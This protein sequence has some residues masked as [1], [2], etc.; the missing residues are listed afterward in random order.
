MNAK[1]D[2]VLTY[3]SASKTLKEQRSI[4]PEPY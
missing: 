1:I 2:V 4:I 3:D